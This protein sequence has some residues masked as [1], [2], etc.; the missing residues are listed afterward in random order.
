MSLDPRQWPRHLRAVTDR[1]AGQFGH[2]GMPMGMADVAA[3]LW[4]DYLKFD[5]VVLKM[6]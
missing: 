4:S 2:P 3:V 6:V 5:P 1:A